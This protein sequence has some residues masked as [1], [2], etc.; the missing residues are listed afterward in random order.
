[1]YPKYIVTTAADKKLWFIGRGRGPLLN[2]M[3][4]GLLLTACWSAAL[5]WW[6]W[7]RA[8]GRLVLLGI[9]LLMAAAVYATLTRSVWIGAG[10]SLMIVVAAAL[11]GKWRIPVLGSMLLVAAGAAA[12][13][14]QQLVAFK[15]DRNLSDRETADSVY[16]RPVLA[17]IAWDMFRDRPCF[18]C[19]FDRYMAEHENYID[20]R[21]TELVLSKGRGFAPHNVPLAILAE[22][23][24]VGL[25]LFAAMLFCW[26]RDAWRLWRGQ[27]A[28][29]A[30]R[31]HGLLFLAVLAAYLA[32]AM[33]HQIAYIPMSNV[34]LFFLAGVV[35]GMES[36]EQGAGSSFRAE[37]AKTEDPRPKTI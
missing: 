33:F 1:V 15:R 14:W 30:A 23:G 18:G 24:L 3:A 10:L 4:T 11:P 35:A 37:A 8:A 27:A 5:M 29:L 2:P 36:R 13:N 31:Q 32:N 20:D 9:S 25:A 12:L 17:K 34:L 6:A 21:S 16:L 19:G 7:W 28:P 22:L 26:T